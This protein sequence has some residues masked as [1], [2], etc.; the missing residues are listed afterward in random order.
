MDKGGISATPE[1]L[2]NTSSIELHSSEQKYREC[3]FGEEALKIS[4]TEPYCLRR[5]IRRG[6]LNISQHYPSQQVL[7]TRSFICLF[8]AE[9]SYSKCSAYTET[10]LNVCLLMLVVFMKKFNE[11]Q[12]TIVLLASLCNVKQ[13]NW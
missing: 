7:T 6:H 5:P 4:S 9:S 3:I 13:I 2:G 10:F 8:T 12:D 11:L 1:Q